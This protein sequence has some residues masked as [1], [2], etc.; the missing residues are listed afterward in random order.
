MS[1]PRF[2]LRP[3][4]LWLH[5]WVGVI[6]GIVV[7]VIAITGGLLVF[8]KEYDRLLHP[9]FYAVKSSAAKLT[10]GQCMDVLYAARGDMPIQ[11]LLLP[12]EASDPL[13]LHSRKAFY[14][15]PA[16]GQVL[17]IRERGDGQLQ[18][19]TKLHINLLQG[20]TGGE[21]VGVVTVLT[22]GLALTGL[23]LWWS[24]QI[25][26]LRKGSSFRRFNLDLHSIAGL[27]SSLFLLIIA[28]SGATMFYGHTP[29]FRAWF[30]PLTGATSK[31]TP[32]ISASPNEG[33]YRISVDEA[34][35]A[36]EAALP[37]AKVASLE[38]PMRNTAPFHL[39]LAFPEDASLA[40][41]SFVYLD[42]YTG[43]PLQVISTREGSIGDRYLSMQLQIHTGTIGG[44]TTKVIAFLVCVAI[45]LQVLS[46]Y[47]LWWKRK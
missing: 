20:H 15:D 4:L 28:A 7:L 9:Q 34:I 46:G 36:A 31:P 5:R 39:Q 38:I 2:S 44:M 45:L 1:L 12:R 29:V 47:V 18:T 23:W 30:Y 11:G 21:V 19:L 6:T 8:E 33:Q 35:S 13:I 32:P 17:G 3:I 40:G 27:Y 14:I 10:A 22:L 37:G 41:R 25:W 42:Q 24:L 43:K 26:S 16:D